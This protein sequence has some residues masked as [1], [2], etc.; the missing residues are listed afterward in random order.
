MPTKKTPAQ[1]QREIDDALS[2]SA[3]ATRRTTS[4]SAWPP[5]VSSH[6]LGT[7]DDMSKGGAYWIVTV[8]TGYRVDYKPWGP[9]T[10]V[11]LGMFPSRRR[12][13]AKIN[14]HKKSAAGAGARSHATKKRAAG[15][16]QAA[17]KANDRIYALV[18][19]KY[20]QSIPVN[21][22]FA[23]VKEAGFRFDPDEE[24]FFLVGREGKATWQLHDESGRAVNHML[25]LQWHKMDTTGRY[26]V[27]SYVS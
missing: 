3:H 18:N 4:R 5:V 20:F 25:V 6:G 23:I 9:S 26:E 2:G 8:P 19:N 1:L 12:A 10:E 22:L 15:D 13:Q 21:D 14:E 7:Y 11:S 17:K 27:V 16:T 24:E